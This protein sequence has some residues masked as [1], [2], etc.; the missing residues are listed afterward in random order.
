[1]K[2]RRLAGLCFLATVAVLAWPHRST[3]FGV[4]QR[5]VVEHVPRVAT[6]TC[7]GNRSTLKVPRDHPYQL[8]HVKPASE[9]HGTEFVEDAGHLA[10]L[11]KTGVFSKVR[12]PE[13]AVMNRRAMRHSEP[14]LHTDAAGVLNEIAAAYT[15]RLQ[16]TDAEGSTFYISSM[17][18]SAEQQADL[19]DAGKS[20]RSAHS[21]GAAFDISRVY[22]PRG[23]CDLA[24][25]ALVEV[26]T[27]FRAAGKIRLVPERDCVHVTVISGGAQARTANKDTPVARRF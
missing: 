8:R 21:F 25:Q 11:I 18:R 23:Q 24:R 10:R 19:Q 17:T 27:D 6:D 4:A 5:V 15:A 20:S 13:G 12:A 2:W 16:D 22:A 1:M 7:V 9:L 26:L 14:V 3:V